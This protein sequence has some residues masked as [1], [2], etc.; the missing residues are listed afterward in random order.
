MPAFRESSFWWEETGNAELEMS[1]RDNIGYS[2]FVMGKKYNKGDV[3]EN[4]CAW[5]GR[6]DWEASESLPGERTAL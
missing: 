6:L 2:S 1:S 3:I 4:L 5:G